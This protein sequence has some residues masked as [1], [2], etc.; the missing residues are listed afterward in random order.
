MRLIPRLD[1]KGPN[2]I[3]GIQFEGL[4]V[5]GSPNDFARRY[6]EQGADEL[7]FIDTVASLYG[8]NNLEDVIREASRDI[9]IPIMVGGGVRSIEDAKRLLRAGADKVAI[10]TAALRDPSLLRDLSLHFG[11]QCVVLSVQAKKTAGGWECY[12]ECGRE[13]TAKDVLEWVRYGEQWAGEI[14]VTSVDRDGTRSGFDLDLMAKIKASVPVI[15]CGGMA[16]RD[17]LLAVEPYCDAV[18]MATCLHYGDMT[19]REMR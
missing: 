17:D 14:L 12:A 19:L 3:K 4:R 15:A 2:L 6:Y 9:F 13:K 11:A 1:I 8:R 18:A 7:L 16:I 10:N 5:L